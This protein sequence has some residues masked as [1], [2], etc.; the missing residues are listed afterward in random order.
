[1]TYSVLSYK[2]LV[3]IFSLEKHEIALFSGL[4]C[5]GRSRDSLVGTATGYRLEGLV[6]FPSSLVHNAQPI[7]YPTAT[8]G[9]ILRGKAAGA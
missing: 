5:N 9:F 6:P 8:G 1:M 4:Y 7:S 2:N 3:L